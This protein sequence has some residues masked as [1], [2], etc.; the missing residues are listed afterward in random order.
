MNLDTNRQNVF[1]SY[2]RRDSVWL[3]ELKPHLGSLA[4]EKGFDSTFWDDTKIDAGTNW[5][6]EINQALESAKVAILLVSKYFLNSEF[7][8]SV[9][10]EI[11]IKAAKKMQTVILPIIVGP[12][13]YEQHPELS[14]F[15][16]V[17]KPSEPLEGM[18]KVQFENVFLK[19]TERVDKILFS[20]NVNQSK[21]DDYDSTSDDLDQNLIESSK[22][23]YTNQNTDRVSDVHADYY[24]ESKT[25][26]VPENQDPDNHWNRIVIQSLPDGWIEFQTIRL[27]EAIRCR[28]KLPQR[29]ILDQIT[30]GL[31]QSI[32]TNPQAAKA[33]FEL[34]VPSALKDNLFSSEGTILV[35]DSETSQ[36]PWELLQDNYGDN[37]APLSVKYPIIRQL[38]TR[39]YTPI[40]KTESKDTLVIADPQIDGFPMLPGARQEAEALKALLVEYGY[41]VN[42]QIGETGVSAIGAIFSQPFKIMH[43][44]GVGVHDYTISE[45]SAKVSGFVLGSDIYFTDNEVKQ[46]RVAPE[47][48]FINAPHMGSHQSLESSEKIDATKAMYVGLHDQFSTIGTDAIIAPLADIDDAAAGIFARTFY[49]GMLSGQNL[50]QAILQARQKTYEAKPDVNTCGVYCCYGDPNYRLV[51][52]NKLTDD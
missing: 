41:N 29:S 47:M 31:T 23:E 3:E 1:I 26:R 18:D 52:P 28:V 34:L 44:A 15:Q 36:Y 24:H 20:F 45:S 8:T 30:N 11:L 22:Q 32:F 27:N 49:E 16:S 43:F 12:C 19:V 13:R 35:L 17:N 6:E 42:S 10:L 51:T 40:Y 46:L 2:S 39:R 4:K 37:E 38:K 21:K 7:I 25:Y 14:K 48:V 9:E 50:G 5:R 33:L